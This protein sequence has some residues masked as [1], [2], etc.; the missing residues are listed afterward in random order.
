MDIRQ[1][2]EAEPLVQFTTMDIDTDEIKL[3]KFRWVDEI[4]YGHNVRLIDQLKLL[5]ILIKRHTAHTT[6]SKISNGYFL[7]SKKSLRISDWFWYCV[8]LYYVSS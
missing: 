3:A 5:L 2:K 8:Y 1:N 4:K 7:Q 6:V